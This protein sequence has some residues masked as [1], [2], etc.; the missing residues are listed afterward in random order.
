MNAK[1]VRKWIARNAPEYRLIRTQY[2]ET[3]QAERAELIAERDDARQ[4][5]ITDSVNAGRL[6]AVVIVGIC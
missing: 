6:A 1:A 5:R 2:L 3:L 4:S